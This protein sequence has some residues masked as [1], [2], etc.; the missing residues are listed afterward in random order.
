MTS[1]GL[2]RLNFDKRMEFPLPFMSD[3]P[4]TFYEY[5]LSPPEGY[6]ARNFAKQIHIEKH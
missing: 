6:I 3:N 2:P 5:P 4:M 1:A